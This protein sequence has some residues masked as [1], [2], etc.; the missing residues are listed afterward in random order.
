MPLKGACVTKR[1]PLDINQPDEAKSLLNYALNSPNCFDDGQ[2]L[3]C[4]VGLERRSRNTVALVVFRGI[5][6]CKKSTEAPERNVSL[7]RLKALI[8][9]GYLHM[10]ITCFIEDWA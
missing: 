4:S 6:Y 2:R 3:P 1:S 10:S 8:Y 5:G 9:Q 7:D